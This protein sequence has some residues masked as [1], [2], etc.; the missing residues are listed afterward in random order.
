MRNDNERVDPNLNSDKKSQSDSSYS[1]VPGGDVN[2]ADFPNNSGDDADSSEH[3]FAVQD[4]QVTTLEDNIFSEASKF[5][6][7]TDAMNSEIDALLRNDT[8]DI[9]DLPKDE[10][11]IGSKLIFKI[12]Y[13]SSGEIDRYKARLV[14]QGFGQKEGIDYEETFSP[15]V[16][17]VTVRCL[18]NVGVSNSW[19]VFQLDVNN[20]FLYG[21]LV[22]AMYMKPP[23]GYFPSD[24]KVYKLKK[25]LYCL[26][27]APRQ[28]NAKLTSTLIENGFSQS[29]YDYSLYTKSNNGI[30]LALLVYV[31]DIIITGN[32]VS[33]IEKFKVYLKSK[34][35][36]KD[37]GKLKYFLAIEVVDTDKGICINQRKYV[38]DLLS[39]YG[40]LACKPAKTPLMSKLSIS[41]EAFDND[42][43]LDNITD[44][45]KLMGKII[46]LT[47]TRLYISYDVH[48]LSQDIYSPFKSHLKIAF[49]ILRYLKSC[50]GLGIHI[51]KNPGM[52]L[53]ASIDADLAK[54]NLK[55]DH[56]FR[57]YPLRVGDNICS[58]NLFPLEM[59]DFDIILGMDWLTQHRATID[60]HTKRVIFGDLNN[61]EFNY[62]GSLPVFID[63]ILVYVKTREEHE[64]H[65]RIVLEI[66]H[67]KKLYAKFSKCDFRLRQVAFFGHIVSA[68][69]IT[70]DPAKVEAN[71]RDLQQEWEP[72]EV[73]EVARMFPDKENF[74]GTSSPFIKSHQIYKRVKYEA[75][76]LVGT[77]QDYE[78]NIQYYTELVSSEGDGEIMGG[79]YKYL[80][81]GKA[82]QYSGGRSMVCDMVVVDW[83]TKSAHFLPIQQGYLVSKLGEIFQQEI[84]RLYDGQI[85][86]TIQTLEDMLRSCALEWMGNWDEYFCLVEFAYNNSWH[87]NKI[88]DDLSLV[89]E[90]EAILDRQ[91]R[92]MRKK[93]FSLVKVL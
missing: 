21:G 91:E 32:Y 8:W 18:L 88:R 31:D 19:S 69:G 74:H 33:K 11:S 49:K 6:H 50:P 37:L 17:M 63:D 41:N 54:Y 5:P 68:D 22:E 39:E 7:W 58:A 47:N 9:F 20:A 80:K 23:E 38:L 67:Q 87:E 55:R 28:W 62:Y 51:I 24:N 40:M 1:S 48:C 79:W 93:T 56:E 3:I 86:R 14:A 29:K 92:V 36:I 81:E 44:Y 65:L 64:D 43:T 60:Y 15:V 45:Q 70:I 71:G 57:N 59:S 25:Y 2:T 72:E 75:E 66:F 30:F 73:E 89:E 10:K 78:A 52:N 26:K 12:K 85:R 84:I 83:L 16:K 35:M 82:G 90:P 77:S 53:K 27:Q 34:Y 46:Y 76:A 4:E 61:P 42:P 13:K